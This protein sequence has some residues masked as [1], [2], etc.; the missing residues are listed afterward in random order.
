MFNEFEVCRI[1]GLTVR[2]TESKNR[3]SLRMNFATN[4]IRFSI[5]F[6]VRPQTSFGKLLTLRRTLRSPFL[7]T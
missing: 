1:F 6:T 4:L 7:F 3:K 2:D 5:Q